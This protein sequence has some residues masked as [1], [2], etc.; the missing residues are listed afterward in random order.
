MKKTGTVLIL[1]VMLLSTVLKANQVTDSLEILLTKT[2]DTSRVKILCDLCWEYR[3][4]SADKALEYGEE[5]LRLSRKIGYQKGIA[6][7]YNDLGI[8]YIDRSSYAKAVEYFKYALNIRR[9]LGDSAG[10]ASLY[11]KLGIVYQKQ[12]ELKEALENQ[13]AALE[14]YEQMG[15][16]RW[17]RRGGLVTASTILPLFIKIWEIFSDHLI[18]TTRLWIKGKRTVTNMER[19]C[20]TEILA[21]CM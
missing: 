1:F 10:I 17:V 20:R 9:Q 6:Q 21:M 3:F 15:Q 4:V 5:A 2:K 7:S 16:E 18:I 11:N 12:G 14:I 8:V 13:I 19:G